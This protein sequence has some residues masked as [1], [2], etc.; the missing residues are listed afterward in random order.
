MSMT[1]IQSTLL[2]AI[3]L[4]IIASKPS[5]GA[6]ASS[7]LR[8]LSTNLTSIYFIGDLHGDVNCAKEWVKQTNLV[9]LTSTPYTWMGEDTEAIV[10]LGDYVDKGSQSA[11]VLT[12]VRELQTTFTNNVV[13][14]L[15]NHDFFQILDASLDYDD[16]NPHPLGHPQHDYAYAFVHPEEYV[17]SGYSPKREDDDEIMKALYD[18]LEFVYDRQLEG[19]VRLCTSDS[20]G[21]SNSEHKDLFTSINPFR[22][23]E[24]LANKARERLRTWRVEY[25]NGLHKAG[26]LHWLIE[27]PV[28]AIV[29][30]A[31]LVHGG[32]SQ[33]IINYVA[34]NAKTNGESVEDALYQMVNKPFRSFFE[35]NLGPVGEDKANSIKDR[36][37]G[38]YIFEIILSMVQHRGYFD[39]AKGCSEVESVIAQLQGEKVNRI[40]VGH[41]PRDYAEELCGG[42]LLASDSSLSRSFRA[43]GNL[44]CPL[45]KKF[46]IKDES[47][48]NIHGSCSQTPFVDK[49][50]GSISVL[51]RESAD[52]EWPNNVKHLTVDELIRYTDGLEDEL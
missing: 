22:G 18:A 38:G 37:Q 15:G 20:C 42:R 14:I 6:I 8:H 16:S 34:R 4:S 27:Q 5:K 51:K 48:S 25:M 26:L 47:K 28:I 12:F 2:L 23:N 17:E 21:K 13:S 44:Y 29:G 33:G 3:I 19:S 41:T 9:N 31:L 39:S 46:V 30:D 32:L 45:D 35:K 40:C 24:E 36:L 43:Y 11:S 10:F 50:E 1:K 52:Y 49:C 7:P